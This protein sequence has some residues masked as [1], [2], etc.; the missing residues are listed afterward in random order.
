MKMNNSIRLSDIK[1]KFGGRYPPKDKKFISLFKKA[2]QGKTP[3]HWALIKR[4]AIKPFSNFRPKINKSLKKAYFNRLDKNDFPSLHVYEEGGK[5]I[6]S[7]D[8]HKYYFYLEL[9]WTEL[10]CFIIGKTTGDFTRHLTK[11]KAPKTPYA[12]ITENDKKSKA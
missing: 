8:Y 5:Y 3:Y 6:M 4:E 1:A 9:N 2:I 11:A 12:H 10:P 7:D